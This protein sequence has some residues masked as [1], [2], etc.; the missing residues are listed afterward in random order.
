[1][2]RIFIV[3][4]YGGVWVYPI[5]KQLSTVNRLIFI[6]LIASIVVFLYKLGELFNL[7]LWKTSFKLKLDRIFKEKI[8][9]KK[10]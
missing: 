9:D 5:L 1:M 2:L 4:Y 8:K 6:G 7:F 3:A 10:N